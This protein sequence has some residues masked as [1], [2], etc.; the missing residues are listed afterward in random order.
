[1]SIEQIGNHYIADTARVVGDVQIGNNVS[2]WYGVAIRGDVAKVTLGDGTNVQDNSV[3]HCD[4]HRPNVIGRNVVIGHRA[5]VHGVEVGDGTLIGMGAILLGGSKIGKG[6]IV[7]AGAVV[8]QNMQVP[9]GTLV[10]GV[11]AKIVRDVTDEEKQATL[12]LAAHYRAL[13]KRHH[14]TPEGP[15]VH[16]NR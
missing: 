15:W 6:C 11:P 12:D 16:Q 4:Q 2:I 1:M 13:A 9:D 8:K 5:I 7:A 3:I 10:M 14:E